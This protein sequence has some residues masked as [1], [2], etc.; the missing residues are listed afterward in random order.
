MY[1]HFFFSNKVHIK[2][3]QDLS[4]KKIEDC[5]IKSQIG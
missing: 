2:M 4:H 1:D 3:R 5:Y